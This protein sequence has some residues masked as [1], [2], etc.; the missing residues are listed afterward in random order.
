MR[1]Y[2]V[3][4]TKE[5]DYILDLVMKSDTEL[6]DPGYGIPVK[7]FTPF[8]NNLANSLNKYRNVIKER[9]YHIGKKDTMVCNTKEK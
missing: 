9:N 2:P 8:K 3:F 7:S 4:K 6:F 5:I 1:R